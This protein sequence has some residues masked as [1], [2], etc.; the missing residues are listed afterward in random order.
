MVQKGKKVL[1]IDT[2]RREGIGDIDT[3]RREGTGDI[4][5]VA[6]EVLLR[7]GGNK[8]EEMSSAWSS[9]LGFPFH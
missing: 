2:D 5:T 9:T 1:V 3:D 6:V 4:D 8:K 7:R